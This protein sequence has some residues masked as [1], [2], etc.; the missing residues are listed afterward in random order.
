MSLNRNNYEVAKNFANDFNILVLGSIGTYFHV[1]NRKIITL[2]G[3]AYEFSID[4][5]GHNMEE[6]IHVMSNRLQNYVNIV[7]NLCINQMK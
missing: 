4:D 3:P 5:R 7:I 2:K 6:I 1:N